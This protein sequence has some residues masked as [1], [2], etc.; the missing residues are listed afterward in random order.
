MMLFMELLLLM[1]MARYMLLYKEIPKKL[2][3][4]FKSAFLKSIKKV[5]NLL[6]VS[7]D[8]E[9]RKGNYI[10]EKCVNMLPMSL[11]RMINL[12]SKESF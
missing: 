7:L 11:F 3:S 9:L 5:G 12:L 10:S 8:S 1:V 6:S 2:F 4:A